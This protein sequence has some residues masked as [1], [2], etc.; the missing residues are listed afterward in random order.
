MSAAM[1]TTRPDDPRTALGQT[2]A[3]VLDG[4]TITELQR[5]S[6]GAS[7]ETWRFLADGVPRIVQRQRAGDQRDMMIEADVVR[8]AGAGGVPVP[9]LLAAEQQADGASFMVLEA[10]EGETIARKIQR[11][12]EFSVARTRLVPDLGR[13]LARIH[14]LDPAS[15]PALQQIDQIAYYTN[16][17]DSLGYPHPALEMVRNWLIDNEPRPSSLAVVHGDFRLG[18]VIV[19]DEGLNAVIDWELAHVGDPMEDLGWLCVKAWRF[20]GGPPVAGLGTY[21]A[22]VGAYEE[23]SGMTVDRVAMHWWEVLGT[24][25]W[26]IMCILQASAHLTGASRSHELA[27]IGRRVCENEYDLFLALEGR[28]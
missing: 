16:V 9:E 23:A 18:N 22:L 25:K 17:L 27:A 26:A 20:G 21:D 19:G 14:A 1:E 6:G 24:W 10:I 11:D 28:W 12:D 3:G 4:A 2:L 5:L 8:A 15:L 13:A 7:R